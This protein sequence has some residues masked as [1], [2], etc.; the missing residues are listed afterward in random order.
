MRLEKRA[1]VVLL[2]L[3]LMLLTPVFSLAQVRDVPPGHWAYEAVRTLLDKGYLAIGED[4]LFRGDEPVDRY[5]LATVVAKIITEIESG[6]AATTPEDVRTLQR[7]SEELREDLVMAYAELERLEGRVETAEKHAAAYEEKMAEVIGSYAALYHRVNALEESLRASQVENKEALEQETARLKQLLD[8]LGASLSLDVRGLREEI[9]SVSELVDER[10]YTLSAADQELR[11][12]VQQL[13]QT[14]QEEARAL[15]LETA[16]RLEQERLE[17]MA[18]LEE[19]EQRINASFSQHGMQLAGQ[20]TDTQQRFTELRKELAELET[21]LQTDIADEAASLQTELENLAVR[22]AS[23]QAELEAEQAATG[24]R[25]V[26][27]DRAFTELRQ[28]VNEHSEVLAAY[29]MMLRSLTEDLQAQERRMLG[30]MDTRTESMVR[31][32]GQLLSDIEQLRAS[33]EELRKESENVAARTAQFEAAL[34]TF[35]TDLAA[36]LAAISQEQAELNARLNT[37]R[38]DV[39]VLQ[40]Q[41]G[42]SESQIAALTRRVR[43]DLSEQLNLSL[44]RERE[45]QDKLRDLQAEFDSYRASTEEQLGKVNSSQML[46]IGALILGAIALFN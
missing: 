29:D 35:E 4:Q 1:T 34:R 7:L 12:Q 9:A 44:L 38:D 40:S 14:L 39:L 28:A 46:S 16:Q 21:R 18:S 27:V 8:D 19:L 3:S 17:R 6:R 23:L 22:L 36:Q 37:V 20:A 33:L 43:E 32:Q 45:L 24:D 41:V 42:L 31:M 25:L 10:S 15:R 5:T 30:E 26:T 2:F 13:A 11:Q